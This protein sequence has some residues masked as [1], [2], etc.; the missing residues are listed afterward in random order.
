MYILQLLTQNLKFT[1][2]HS[3][4]I[5]NVRW[6]GASVVQHEIYSA[7]KKTNYTI[8]R[9]QQWEKLLHNTS[10]CVCVCCVMH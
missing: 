3:A 7:L 4:D 9:G 8:H 5:C 1:S 10:R 6:Q 2:K